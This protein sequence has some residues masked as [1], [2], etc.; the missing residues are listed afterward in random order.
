M[1]QITAVDG[2]FGTHTPS[3]GPAWHSS[4]LASRHPSQDRKGVRNPG[5]FIHRRVKLLVTT[6]DELFGA[7]KLSAA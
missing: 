6:V 1:P 3:P 5:L 2:Q 7:H 4:C